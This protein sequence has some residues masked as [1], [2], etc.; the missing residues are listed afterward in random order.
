MRKYVYLYAYDIVREINRLSPA[1]ILHGCVCAYGCIHSCKHPY[2]N[3]ITRSNNVPSGS[4]KCETTHAQPVLEE[5]SFE[6][7]ITMEIIIRNR[8]V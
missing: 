8:S 3:R 5:K 6:M 2:L 7:E 4:P 1:Y